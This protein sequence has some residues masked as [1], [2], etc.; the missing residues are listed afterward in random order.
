[1]HNQDSNQVGICDSGDKE[2]KS[3]VTVI[4]RWFNYLYPKQS[5][6]SFVYLGSI[7]QVSLQFN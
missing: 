3:R 5:V 6:P 1:M 2:E 4:Y 7:L